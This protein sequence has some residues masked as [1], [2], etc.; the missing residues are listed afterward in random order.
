MDRTRLQ[1][2]RKLSP[3][4]FNATAKDVWSVF[5]QCGV[6]VLPV[7]SQQNKP[8]PNAR[9]R[10]VRRRT[11]QALTAHETV[12]YGRVVIVPGDPRCCCVRVAGACIERAPPPPDSFPPSAVR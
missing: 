5:A 1:E 6:G 8:L 4:L 2:R 7:R 9:V 11:H 12:A 10:V 3:A